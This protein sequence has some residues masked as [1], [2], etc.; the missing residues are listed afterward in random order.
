[1]DPQR[2]PHQTFPRPSTF[3]GSQEPRN[4]SLPTR[5]YGPSSSLA[6]GQSQPPYDPLRRR[7]S[8]LSSGPPPPPPSLGYLSHPFPHD[9]VSHPKSSQPSASFTPLHAEAPSNFH[10]RRSS[11]GSIIKHGEGGSKEV[12]SLYR[13][14]KRSL[15]YSLSCSSTFVPPLGYP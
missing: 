13:E 4:T 12:N 6:N 15:L 2:P 10:S 8:E 9:I 1:M 5:L 7:E 14:G 3:S 11:S